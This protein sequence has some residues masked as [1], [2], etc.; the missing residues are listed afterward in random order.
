MCSKCLQ[1]GHH[2]SVCPNDIVCLA[3]RKE[4]HRRGDPSCPVF[5]QPHATGRGVT[6]SDRAAVGGERQSVSDR[7]AGVREVAVAVAVSEEAQAGSG[8]RVS[9]TGNP[10]Q[11]TPPRG[12]RGRERGRSKARPQT[13]A[14]WV[15]LQKL[16]HGAAQL[17]HSSSPK[18][19]HPGG[20]Q[21]SSKSRKRH[22]E[23]VRRSARPEESGEES[24]S[25]SGGELPASPQVPEADPP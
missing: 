17:K 20:Q 22:E 14:S 23:S 18:R 11:Q 5:H 2:A 12:E 25:G 10:V 15:G 1:P 4:G 6:D 16:G 21:S 9:N 24:E 7:G 19:R 13:V 8:G 3:C